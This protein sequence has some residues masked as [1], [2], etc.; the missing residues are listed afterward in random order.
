MEFY[1]NGKTYDTDKYLYVVGTTYDGKGT[2][3]PS[4]FI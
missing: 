2:G 3:Q 4:T 1:F